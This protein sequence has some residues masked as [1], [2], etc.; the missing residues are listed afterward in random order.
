MKILHLVH[1]PRHSGAE[2]L[3]RDLCIQHRILGA[4]SAIASNAPAAEA[5]EP[6]LAALA[7]AGVEL[8]VPR[9]ELYGLA[10]SR[11][12][13]RAFAAFEPDVVFAHSLLPALYGRIAL[14]MVRRRPP[15][16]FVLHSSTN[17]FSNWK[18]RWAERMLVPLTR[19]VIAVAE[20]AAANYKRNVPWGPEP[21]VISNGVDV[22]RF[23][24]TS[25]KRKEVRDHLQIRPHERILLQLGRIAP[26]KQQCFAVKSLMNV[27]AS[28]PSAS[29]WFA[30]VVEDENYL[31]ELVAAIEGTGLG[32][33]IR[34]LGPRRDV[35]NLLAAADVYLMPSIAE[36]HSIALLEALSSGVPVVASDIPSFAFARYMP[37]VTL[38]PLDNSDELAAS[39]ADQLRRSERYVRDLSDYDAGRTARDYLK[40]AGFASDV[41]PA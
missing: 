26:I 4:R 1:I 12:F 11:N 24:T 37:G 41:G 20:P 23:R 17:D 29:L 21:Q 14:A 25:E 35:P 28:N 7:E 10:R 30:G 19:S 3:A 40:I 16:H 33:R 5:F 9:E 2:V 31:R 18:A 39:V 38:V 27:L 13:A 6:E 34:F 22:E 36:Q 15:I 8:Y 32:G